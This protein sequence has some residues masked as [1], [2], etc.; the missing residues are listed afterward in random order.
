MDLLLVLPGFVTKPFAHILPPLERAK[1]TTVDVITLDSLEI[2]KRARVPPADV[3]RLSSCIVEALHTDVGFEKPQTNTGTSD[4]PSSS[5]NSDATTRKIGSTKRASQWNTISTL[6]PAMDALLGGG[7]PTGYVTE[8]TGESGSGKTQFLLSLCLAVQLP[9]PQ[10]LQRRAIYISTEHS[11]STPRLSQIL[12]CH[13]VLST[14]PAEQTPSLQD[15]LSINAMDLESQDHILNYHLP[16]AIERY[17]IGLVIIDS[18]TSNYRAEHESN[19]LQANAKRSSELAKLGHLLRNLAVKEDIAIVLANQ[20]SDRFESL[21]GS[22]PASRTGFPSMSQT[23]SRGSGPASPFP[24]SRTEQ[25]ST[26][27]GQ[28][29]PSSSPAISSSPYHAPDDKNFD[30]SYLVSPRVRN[31]MLNVAHQERFYSGW[32]DGAYPESGSLKNPALGLVWSTQIACRIALKKEESHAVGVSMGDSAY[33]AATQDASH[34]RNGGNVDAHLDADSIAMP[35]PYLKNR[36]SD[37]RN[38]TPTSESTTR[39]TMKLVFSPW[40]AGPKDSPR[41]GQPSRRSGEVEFEIWKGGLR[42]TSY[43]E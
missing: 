40:T 17:D 8:V 42:S 2:A 14:L 7:I 31:S 34:Y 29:P 3:R 15:I 12:E 41:K 9:K 28:Q 32:G 1:V 21:K 30:G 13:P 18:I 16:V 22:E 6:D 10:G 5:I 11:L 20:V 37:P 43:G 4:G 36:V 25:L 33:L 27:N 24:K 39:R 35:A 26:R 23:P 38:P 19:S